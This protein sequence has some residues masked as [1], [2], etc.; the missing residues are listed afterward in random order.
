MKTGQLLAQAVG[1][2]FRVASTVEKNNS[3]NNNIDL[4]TCI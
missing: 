1:S 3:N 2:V 4:S